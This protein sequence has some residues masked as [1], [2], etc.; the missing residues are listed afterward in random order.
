MKDDTGTPE[1]LTVAEVAHYLRVGKSTVWRWIGS[2]QLPAFR[3]GRGWRVRRQDLENHIKPH[4]A[5][6]AEQPDQ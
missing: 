5:T 6:R 3:I 1:F 4:S 2:G